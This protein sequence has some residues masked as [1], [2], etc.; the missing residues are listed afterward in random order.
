MV[1][2]ETMT[3]QVAL[4]RELP[5]E[6]SRVLTALNSHRA[7]RTLRQLVVDQEES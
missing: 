2:W 7:L 1:I 3:P 6:R 5:M 4:A